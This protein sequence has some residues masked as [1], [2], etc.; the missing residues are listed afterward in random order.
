MS[1]LFL[2]LILFHG[3]LCSFQ[4]DGVMFSKI[5]RTATTPSKW[6]LSLN[7][8]LTPFTDFLLQLQSSIDSLHSQFSVHRVLFNYTLSE[9]D[10]FIINS[11]AQQLHSLDLKSQD[12]SAQWRELLSFEQ[13]PRRSLLPFLGETFSFL[14]GT[15]TGN[16]VKIIRSHLKTVQANQKHI[17]HLLNHSMTIIDAQQTHIL[18]N[19]VKINEIITTVGRLSKHFRDLFLNLDKEFTAFKRVLMFTLSITPHFRNILLML[20]QASDYIL[21]LR[22]RLNA[23]AVG[24][25]SPNVIMPKKLYLLL[26]Q[27]RINLPPSLGLPINSNSDMWLYYQFLTCSAQ[28]TQSDVLVIISVPLVDY[29]SVFDIYRV[30]PLPIPLHNASHLF[31]SFPLV[32][33]YELESEYLAVDPDRQF[34]AFLSSNHIQTCNNPILTFCHIDVPF[35]AFGVAPSCLSSLFSND[36]GQVGRLCK[37]TVYFNATLPEATLV[38]DSGVWVIS[39][40]EPFT[41]SVNCDKYPVHNVL[42]QPPAMSLRLHSAC[43]A[44]SKF[45]LLPPL[46]QGASSLSLNDSLIPTFFHLSSINSSLWSQLH[47]FIR[48]K[49]FQLP[50]PLPTLSQIPMSH[51]LTAVSR[52]QPLVHTTHF[53]WLWAMI[54]VA[55]T[56][57]VLVILFFYLHCRDRCT[58]CSSAAPGV[59]ISTTSVQDS[60]TVPVSSI[61]SP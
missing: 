47:D 26:E 11:L 55:Y 2:F 37:K 49:S 45:F 7:F 38:D 51:L 33:R 30:T 12:L 58:C 1:F 10:Q 27:I 50:V 14:F 19:R 57:F 15:A 18:K 54:F 43:K 8:Q 5:K 36:L 25:L 16:D 44:V 17:F 48:N 21:E 53:P 4:S 29:A 41:V 42:I 56:I 40:L 3:G 32:A 60:E 39:T 35:R 22:V 34:Y 46:V 31:S 20:D 52:P 23:L 6:I 24:R 13:R 28:F 9:S 59:G 61:Q